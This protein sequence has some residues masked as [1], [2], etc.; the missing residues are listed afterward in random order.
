MSS[1]DVNVKGNVLFID[2]LL[3]YIDYCTFIR[4]INEHAFVRPS[5]LSFLHLKWHMLIL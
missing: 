2:V 5:L 3:L 4:Q 1:D